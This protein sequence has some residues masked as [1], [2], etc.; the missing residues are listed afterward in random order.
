MIVGEMW[1]KACPMYDCWRNVGEGLPHVRAAFATCKKNKFKQ[2]PS[3]SR[4]QSV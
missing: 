1:G 4:N 2:K 3:Y